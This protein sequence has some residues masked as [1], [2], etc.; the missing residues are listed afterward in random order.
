M[1]GGE[2]V[3]VGMSCGHGGSAK[4]AVQIP[5]YIGRPVPWQ[6]KEKKVACISFF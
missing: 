1:K 3:R 6:R 5:E 2:S 4:K